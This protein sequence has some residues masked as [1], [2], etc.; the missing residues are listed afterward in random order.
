M[1]EQLVLILSGSGA[2]DAIRGQMQAYA[3]AL[4][5]DG[6]SIVHISLTQ[7]EIAY[8]F[9]Q[10]AAGKV[11][12]ALTWLGLG[13]S[14]EVADDKGNRRNAWEACGVPLL[15]LQGDLPAY[16]KDFHL[17]EPRSSVNLYGPEEFVRFRTRWLPMASSLAGIVPPLPLAPMDRSAVDLKKRRS[18]KLVFLKNGNSPVELGN[19]WRE[20]LPPEISR[21]LF[22]M[23]EDLHSIGLRT[24]P[25]Y[26][27]EEV[28]NH[29]TRR[30]IE[31][32]TAL[33]QM[34]FFAS[35][36]DD[37]LR[38][39]KSTMIAEALLDFPVI[40]QGAYWDHLDTIGRKA[41]VT[42]GKSYAAS[43]KT[44]AEQLGI[45]DM[46]PNVDSSPHERVQRAAGS[47]AAVLTNR[48]TWLA[49]RFP[50][51]QELTFEFSVDSIRERV[52]AALAR[53][54]RFLDLGVSFGERFRSLFS[55]DKFAA[56]IRMVA[57]LARLQWSPQQPILQPFFVWSKL[58]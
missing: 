35:Q 9:E 29:L 42:P 4:I 19:M 14:I 41:E 32:S 18:G 38:R 1:A 25:F 49:A 16:Y 24:G 58:R 46:S 2:N 47:F 55:P 43:S 30:G 12:F 34:P 27:G 56:H 21:I 39:T 28:A 44:Y 52:D 31:P 40:I 23:S 57:E 37:Y 50:E 53:P 15:K 51:S 3:D 7:S 36:V 33:Y 6:Q 13:Q 26:V 54:D 5:G 48:Q 10:M 8:A 20:R 17:D 45:I 11:S 22:E